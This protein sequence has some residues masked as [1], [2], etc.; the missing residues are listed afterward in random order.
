M[1]YTNLL[2]HHAVAQHYQDRLDASIEHGDAKPFFLWHMLVLFGLPLSALLTL[3]YHGSRY[4]RLA[5]FALILSVAFDMIKNRRAQL[6]ANGYM[7]EVQ[8][9]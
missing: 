4:I 6:G 2:S 9:D 8:A 5:V 3:D 1:N 7:I